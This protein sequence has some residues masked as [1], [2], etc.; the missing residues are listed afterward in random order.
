MMHDSRSPPQ[1][2]ALCR[3][4]VLPHSPAPGAAEVRLVMLL[5]LTPLAAR[6]IDRFVLGV[7]RA[8]RDGG[9]PV[10]MIFAQAPVPSFAAELDRMGASWSTAHFPLRPAE[11]R[12]LL[13]P[14]RVVLQTHFVSPFDRTLL[15]TRLRRRVTRLQVVDH[16]SV[17]IRARGAAMRLLRRARGALAGRLI[18]EIIAVSGFVRSRLEQLSVP[19]S[20][21]RTI[22]NGIPLDRCP[23]RS[24]P[25]RPGPPRVA[26]VGQLREEKGTQVL[27]EAMSRV[28]APAELHLAGRGP[29]LDRLRSDAARLGLRARFHGQVPDA[30]AFFRDADLAVVPSL[31]DEA[32]GLVA[33][34]AMA[35]GTPLV[36]ADSGALPEVVGEAGVV[37]PRGDPRALA[38]AIDALLADEARRVH[39]GRAGRA[40]A[41]R[42][43]SLERM[44]AEHVAATELQLHAAVG[45]P[46]RR[47]LGEPGRWERR[48]AIG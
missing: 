26:F 18:D 46:G 13:P 11:L 33:A 23:P 3:G 45:T 35:S 9:W 28:R 47:G 19:P 29:E 40:R 17:P 22:L 41:L 2:A 25:R 34:E 39:L 7:G 12:A 38:E 31:W 6:T 42:C 36:V 8:V 27:L 32:F 15:E 30:P 48:S 14:G 20:R 24:G 4:P 5:D 10:Q 43:F 37:V 1:P 16:S 21:I 44:I